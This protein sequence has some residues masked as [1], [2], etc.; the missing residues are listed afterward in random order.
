MIRI[1]LV[2]AQTLLTA[3]LV[4]GWMV[5]TQ[6][7]HWM[8]SLGVIELGHWLAIPALISAIG[9]L[10]LFRGWMRWALLNI[11]LILVFALMVP[12]YQA[13]KL[14]KD[15]QFTRL[16]SLAK[17][18]SIGPMQRKVYWRNYKDQ[19]DAL[20][21]RPATPVS[22]RMP[23]LLVL[24]AGG[25]ENGEAEEFSAW[26]RTLAAKGYI[27][28]SMNYHLA[29]HH[30]WP[31]QREDVRQAIKYVNEHADELGVDPDKMVIMGRSAGGQIATAC[32]STMPDLKAK[33]VIA[34]Y[35]PVDMEFAHTFSTE[36][37]IIGALKLL[38]Q[39]LG[40]D[41]DTA[42]DNY[43]S[44]SAINFVG[45]AAPPTL[46]LHGTRDALVW[47]E[48]SIRY[49]A[50]FEKAGIGDRCTFVQLPWAVHAF[51][52]FPNSPGG[53]LS[54]YEVTEFLKKI[55]L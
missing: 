34:F 35:S 19:L 36:D 28:F 43:R 9:G 23:W 53:Q 14:D 5:P 32:A 33:G 27:I 10:L 51:D 12:A 48:Q 29:P 25:W 38:R 55:G 4:R 44:A 54:M 45:K 6:K 39:Y 11:G 26:N 46:L 17:T 15:F 20:I 41:P 22:K 50:R 16:W 30:P 8:L 49:K 1:C 52:Y 40:G 37:D 47:V 7:W 24:H 13:S 21:Y 31:A 18:P 2:A 42:A 3:F